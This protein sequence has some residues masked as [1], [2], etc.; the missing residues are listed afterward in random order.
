MSR[1][2]RLLMAQQRAQNLLR[3]LGI[4]E[5]PVDPVAI[6]A[7]H[8]IIVEAKPDTA[9]GVS[10]MLLRH[11]NTF[12]ILYATHIESEGFRRFSIAHEL[13]HYFLDGHIDHI[14]PDDG[15][16]ASHAGFVSGDPYELEAD[17]FAAG[18]LMPATLFRRALGKHNPGFDV[19]KSV[20]ATCR[21]S[22]TATALRYA[23]LTEDAVAV[24]LST[25]Q[26]IDFCRLSGTMKSLREITWLKKGMA[27][28]RR[29]VTARLNAD[30]ARVRSADRDEEEIDICEWLG[31]NRSVSATEEVIGLGSYGKTLTVI[32]CPTLVEE[33][34]RDEDDD[35]EDNED[36][37]ESWT[38][39]FRR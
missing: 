34:F 39:R 30:P 33:T 38:P 29:T 3:E 6:A 4:N 15:F 18:L 1:P 7:R 24:I 14:L 2:L 8:D 28:P 5:L 31:G 12:G 37:I 13:G 17:Q 32:A 9:Q 27:V 25:G 23:E 22:L 19:V 20:A 16:H 35:D 36:L 10:G 26:T 11:G 21:T